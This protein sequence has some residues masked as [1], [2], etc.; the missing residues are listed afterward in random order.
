LPQD[1]K[2]I[3]VKWVFKTNLKP[4]GHVTKYKVRLVT[5][6]FQEKYGEDYYEVYAPIVRMETIKL[7][8]AIAIKHNRSM[9]QLDVKS[10]F[11]N[12]ELKEEI[13]VSQ[14]PDFEIKKKEEY[15]YKLDKALYGLKQTPR[16]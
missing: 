16:T 5:R 6:G 12:G 13:Y 7:I 2:C 3:D 9:Y 8:F 1:K 15:V 14:P 10:A 4:Y 11:L